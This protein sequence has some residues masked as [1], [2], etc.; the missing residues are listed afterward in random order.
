MRSEFSK[1]AWSFVIVNDD[2]A[3]GLP[4]DRRAEACRLMPS[5]LMISL[6]SLQR[7][8]HLSATNHLGHQVASLGLM[9][10]IS[11]LFSSTQMFYYSEITAFMYG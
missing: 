1:V 10:A 5:P 6:N 9:W 8:R 7:L 3:V 2:N 11:P 4:I